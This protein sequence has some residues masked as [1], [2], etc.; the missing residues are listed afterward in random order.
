MSL[1]IKLGIY[2]Q[3]VLDTK[4][5]IDELSLKINELKN[6]RKFDKLD[7]R[8]RQ[9]SQLLKGYRKKDSLIEFTK[10]PDIFSTFSGRG[11]IF[12][13][14]STSEKHI[15]VT[16]KSKYEEFWFVLIVAIIGIL[17]MIPMLYFNVIQFYWIFLFMGFLILVS[18]FKIFLLR[19][20]IIGLEKELNDLMKLIN[21]NP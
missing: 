15:K 3:S 18:G 21:N 4:Y 2:K 13:S 11:D 5:K 17:V 10:T 9:I 8:S 20:D 6:T 12:M 19:N 7:S 14:E 1:V 16:Y